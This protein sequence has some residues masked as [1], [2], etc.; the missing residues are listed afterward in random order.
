MSGS[1]LSENMIDQIVS[2]FG[3]VVPFKK[4][5]EFL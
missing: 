1:Y 5:L 3:V 2:L 4:G